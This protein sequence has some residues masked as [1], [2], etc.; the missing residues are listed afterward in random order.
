MS[1]TAETENPAPKPAAKRIRRSAE[2][3]RRLILDAAAKRLADQGPEGIRL[4]DIARDVGISHPAI[5]HHFESRD[6]LVKALVK[7]ATSQLHDKLIAV[8]ESGYDRT[9]ESHIPELI[10][11][12]FDAMADQGTASLLSW[13]VQTGNVPRKPDEPVSD[14]AMRGH[15]ERVQLAREAGVEPPEL[16]DTLFMTLLISNLACGEALTGGYYY[17]AVGLGSDEEA[18]KRFRAWVGRLLGRHS[19]PEPDYPNKWKAPA[20]K[21]EA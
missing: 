15:A 19:L 2:E 3:S 16:E 9:P 20:D 4:Q 7:R 11:G 21:G 8:L 5:L 12:T 13:L 17:E 1:K 6:G 10:D 18:R 14:I